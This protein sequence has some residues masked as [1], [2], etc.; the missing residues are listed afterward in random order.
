MCL[1]HTVIFFGV[2]GHGKLAKPAHQ[3]ALEKSPR[4]KD[5]SCPMLQ[6]PHKAM[7]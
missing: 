7:W 4:I 5:Q 1:Q 6:L 2:S 3:K